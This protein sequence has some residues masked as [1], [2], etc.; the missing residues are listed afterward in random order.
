MSTFKK[1]IA[2]L[3]NIWKKKVPLS[4]DNGEVSQPGSAPDHKAG[5]SE[6]GDNPYF[7]SRK[8]WLDMYGNLEEKYQKAQRKNWVLI[9]LVMACA[10][11]LM[12]NMFNSKYIPFVSV[13]QDDN[14]IYSSAATPTKFDE[15]KPKLS[16][17]F[18]FNFI[19]ALREVSSDGGII[20]YN[21]RYAYAFS[22]QSATQNIQELLKARNPLTIAQ[23]ETINVQIN[24]VNKLSEH[25][26]QVI[27]SELRRDA[28]SGLINAKTQYLGDFTFEWGVPR[29]SNTFIRKVNPLGFYITHFSIS[30]WSN[31]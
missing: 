25:T 18:L 10:I 15:L 30:T 29:Q 21:Q 31:S 16:A 27:W 19:R 17:F 9:G 28:K 6:L 11:A 3:Q 23:K 14:V 1:N 22:K 24:S 2:S 12:V 20:N 4:L 5:Q 7:Q 13:I 26:F 8:L